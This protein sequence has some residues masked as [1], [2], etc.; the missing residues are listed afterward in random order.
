MWT[1]LD[2]FKIKSSN[3][4]LVNMVMTPLVFVRGREFFDQLSE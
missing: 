4:A 3:R 1:H 2:W